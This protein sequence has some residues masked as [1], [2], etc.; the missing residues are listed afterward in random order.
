MAQNFFTK[1]YSCLALFLFCFTAPYLSFSQT[2]NTPFEQVFSAAGVTKETLQKSFPHLYRVVSQNGY[3]T[4]DINTYIKANKNEWADFTQLPAIKKLNIAWGTLGIVAPETAKVFEHS[5]YQWYMAAHIS[6]AKKQELFPHFP[7]P[8]LKNEYNKELSE[9]YQ[10]IGTWQR[11]FPQEYEQFLN[12]PELTAL[13]PYYNGYYHLPYIPKFIGAKVTT[14]KPEKQ[15]TGNPIMDDYNYQ[16]Q[17]RNWYFVFKPEQFEKLYG[18]D[19]KFPETFDAAAYRSQVIAKLNE[20]KK[21]NSAS[22]ADN[23]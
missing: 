1:R 23:H 15:H 17:L 21:K 4:N 13:N 18:N 2:N 3:S 7:L 10:R 12:T 14:A 6:T 11:L 8:D 22:P 19:Y 20:S 9:Y 16:L 5:L